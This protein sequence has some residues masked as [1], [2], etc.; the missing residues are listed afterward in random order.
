VNDF[1]AEQLFGY[2]LASGIVFGFG[3]MM[4]SFA[5]FLIKE[6]VSKAKHLQFLSGAG[7]LNFWLS[8]FVWDLCHFI[9]CSILI[10]I[11]WTIFYYASGLTKD[12]GYFL[13]GPR[14]G[15]T[16]LL[17]FCYAFSKIP[18]T[19][20]MSY[21]FDIPASGFAWITIINIITSNRKGFFSSTSLDRSV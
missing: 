9:V 5:V 11:V 13:N 8:T 17:F 15:Y 14:L 7:G 2:R 16:I 19:Y 1:Q 12:L 10:F 21:L 20:L 3:F 6:R 4:A 18:M